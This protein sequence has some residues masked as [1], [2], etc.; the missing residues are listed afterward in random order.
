MIRNL[1][2][3][4]RPLTAMAVVM[5]IALVPFVVGVFVDPRLIT[6]VPAWLKPAKFAISTA[7][8]ALTLAWVFG[9][10]TAWR[11]VRAI[12]G[13]TTAIVF[14]VEVA[15]IAVQAWRGTTSHFNVSSPLNAALF[16]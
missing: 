8:Y 3:N 4:S 2:R 7:I 9:A 13:W 16:Y 14:A 15:I 5:L 1:W 6:G 11:R 10:L 12:A